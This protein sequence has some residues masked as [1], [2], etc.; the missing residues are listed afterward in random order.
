MT[1]EETLTSINIFKMDSVFAEVYGEDSATITAQRKRYTRAIEAFSAAFSGPATSTDSSRKALDLSLFSA[2]GRTEIGGNHTDHQHGRVLAAA[3]DLDAIG[4]VARNGENVIHL[5]SEGYDPVEINLSDLSPK[6]EEKGT[7][8]ALIRGV[9]SGFSEMGAA[10]QGLDIYVTSDVLSGS[11]LSSSAAF[12]VLLG[13]IFDSLFFG[14]KAGAQKIAKIGQT[15]EN[16]YF[17]KACGL[18]DQMVSAVGGFVKIDFAD[19]DNPN[20]DTYQ[21][22]LEE[23][24]IALIVTDTRGSHASLSGEYT[25]IPDEMRSVAAY[26]GKDYLRDVD[27]EEFYQ[28]LSD[29]R[30]ADGIS[31]RAIL[32]AAH[33]FGEDIRAEKE[34]SALERGDL[35]G[36]LALVNES[37]ESS[38]TLLQN[39]YCCETPEEQGIPLALMLSR[40]VLGKKGACRVHGGGFAGTI[41]AFV[42]K[43]K[44]D[45]YV[46]TMEHVFG[47]GACHI[48]K[49]RR[50]G[51][52]QI[53]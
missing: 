19:P 18:M 11:G 28:S 2:P 6:E 25:A 23:A 27:P 42:P 3:V 43:E 20:I 9:A 31:D 39:L 29:L 12:E 46:R 32:R 5:K 50:A 36:F 38:A 51:G 45:E 16:R 41:Q 14:G 30:K 7:T 21:C 8:A 34:A 17:G 15:A 53:L 33:F 26:F 48:L 10:L 4:V 24:G 35:E 13:T 52:V 1:A 49:I 22:N 44:A 37:G 40:H 47:T